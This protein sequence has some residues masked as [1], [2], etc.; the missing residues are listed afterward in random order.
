MIHQRFIMTKAGLQDMWEK[1]E[2]QA[3]GTCPRYYCH[4]QPLLPVGLSALP[5]EEAARVY[6][7]NCQDLYIPS[8]QKHA[9]MDGVPF[10]PSFAHF[11]VRTVLYTNETKALENRKG[12]HDWQ[13]YVPKIYGFRIFK[14][15][16]ME[17]I[18]DERPVDF[19]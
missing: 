3:Y 16:K 5:G 9:K 10:G 4:E 1:F 17:R 18:R 11:F 6:C 2:Q 7:L 8:T 13:I 12:P 19:K 15:I 14:E